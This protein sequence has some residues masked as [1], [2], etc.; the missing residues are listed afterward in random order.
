MEGPPERLGSYR[1]LAELQAGLS[2]IREAPREL[3][4]VDAIVIRPGVDERTDLSVAELSP[5]RG[6]HGDG[7]ERRFPKDP[8]G[9]PPDPRAQITL[10][11]SRAADLVAGDRLRWPLAG[12]Q[13]FVDFDLSEDQLS[14]GDTLHVGPVILRISDKPH[15]GCHKFAARFGPV[16]LRFVN[17]DEG[18]ALRLRGIYGTV[19]QGGTLRV[20][21][22]VRR[23]SRAGTE[24]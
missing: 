2:S 8:P 5:Q 10:M 24:T 11:S 4:R 14:P 6:V 15:R 23:G 19:V 21:D 17:S 18:R 16:A 13:L 12:D 7:W 9:A 22:L 20:G 1:S 3:G